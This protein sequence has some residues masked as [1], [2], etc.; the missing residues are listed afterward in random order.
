MKDF[1]LKMYSSDYFT[2]VLTIALV[3]LVILFFVVLF[4]GKKDKKLQETQKLQKI[5]DAFKE[6][7]EPQKI[8]I[9][10][11]E[12]KELPLPENE[13]PIVED[14]TQILPVV[15]EKEPVEE[16]IPEP[17]EDVKATIMEPQM[18]A[19]SEI[20]SIPEENNKYDEL[21]NSLEKELTELANLKNEF[22]AIKVPEKEEQEEIS[23]K[24][25]KKEQPQVFSSVFVN[26]SAEDDF[27]LPTLKE[28]TKEEKETAKTPQESEEINTFSF[29]DISGETYNLDNK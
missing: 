23:V 5:D 11:T 9:T 4:F 28:E 29:D 26:N 14:K 1:I 2:L 22:N 17:K 16:K 21:S 3:V 20:K 6:K 24:E 12:K 25:E 8:E 15:E 19:T 13:A 7:S 18:E 27:E 10:T